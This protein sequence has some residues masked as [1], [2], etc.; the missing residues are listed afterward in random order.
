APRGGRLRDAEAREG[1]AVVADAETG[2]TRAHPAPVVIPERLAAQL[3]RDAARA[4]QL[5]VAADDPD[6]DDA[7][8]GGV[9]DELRAAA[10]EHDVDPGADVRGEERP[11]RVRD[12]SRG[13][14]RDRLR[15]AGRDLGGPAPVQ[16]LAPVALERRGE[17]R[18]QRARNLRGAARRS[19]VELDGAPAAGHVRLERAGELI[20]DRCV[21]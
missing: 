10:A 16:V 20:A 15:E 11:P 3:G 1:V 9:L 8:G 14:V 18:R 7:A 21:V 2:E 12:V 17:L 4:E 13:A 19:P 5:R 6:V